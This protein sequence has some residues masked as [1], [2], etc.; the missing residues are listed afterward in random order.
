MLALVHEVRDDEFVGQLDSAYVIETRAVTSEELPEVALPG[1]SG[2]P[3]FTVSNDP[4]KLV[5]PQLCGV[6]KEGWRLD[7]MTSERRG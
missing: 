6:V 7:S 3:A 1:L 5:A 4:A 2:S